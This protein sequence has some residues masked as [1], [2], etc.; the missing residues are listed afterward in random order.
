M[1]DALNAT[2]AGGSGA[3]RIAG[4][5]GREYVL[6]KEPAVEEEA[7]ALAARHA[8]QPQAAEGR[9]AGQGHGTAA[10]QEPPASSAAAATAAG[11]GTSSA[12]AGAVGAAAEP[13]VDGAPHGVLDI[14]F[15]VGLGDSEGEESGE[16]RGAECRHS[17]QGSVG[18]KAHCCAACWAD[19][20]LIHPQSNCHCATGEGDLDWEDVDVGAEQLQQAE[21]PQH[22]RE[23]AAARQRYWSLSHGFQMGRKLA[24]WG[25]QEEQGQAGEQAG[26]QEAPAAP[27]AAA[28]A[29]GGLA[30]TPPRKKGLIGES[31]L[32]AEWW[33]AAEGIVAAFPRMQ[34]ARHAVPCRT[35]GRS[36]QA[37]GLPTL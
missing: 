32:E 20:C 9:L 10:R 6:H 27:A 24:A 17:L 14:C 18:R 31:S 26:G 8:P 2:A 1:K 37:T 22:W 25:E 3:R 35:M 7:A 34:T 12:P 21:Q 5:A 30:S 4:E 36:V 16:R 33:A 28:G 13:A 23:R 19:C 29:G 11:H 15:E